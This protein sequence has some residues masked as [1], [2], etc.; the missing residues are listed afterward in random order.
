[1]QELQPN[2]TV[3]NRYKVLRKLGAG[4]MGSVYLCE[5][6]VENNIKVALKILISD[7][8][9]DQDIWAKGEYE[10]LTRLRHPNLARVY[11]FG[12]IGESK[13]YFIVSEFIK[14][15]DLFSATEYL[16]YDELVD[17]IV[18]ICR[19]LE[20]IHSQG[21]VHFDVKPD[22]IL[23]TRYKT[24]GIKEGSKVQYNEVD[25]ATSK[26]SMFAKPNV[27]L[28]DFGL[29]EKITG[30]FNFA[31]KGTL[32]Y[33]APEILN[34]QTP[35]KRADLYSL[36][37]TLYQVTNRDLPFYQEVTNFSGPPITKRSDL[38]GIHMKKHPEF[39]RTIILKLIEERPEDR[40]Q[41]AKEVTQFINKHS[42]YHF[43]IETAETRASYFYSPRLVGRRREMNLLKEYHERAF[44]PHRWKESIVA[45]GVKEKD[46]AP[47]AEDGAGED[48]LE[49]GD[50]IPAAPEGESEGSS[51]IEERAAVVECPALL[52]VSGEMGSGKSRLLE[53]FQHFLKLNDISLVVGS[54]YEGNSKAYQPFVEVLRQ[55]VYAFGLDSEFFKKYRQEFWK[56]LPE[57]KAQRVSDEDKDSSHRLDKEKLYFIE[58][59]S[60][61]LLEAAQLSPYVLVI[62]NLHWVDE[63]SVDFLET[64]LRRVGE[65]H[66]KGEQL[67][68]LVIASLRP[69]ELPL[70][71][72]R[73]LLEKLKRGG[74]C[75]DIPIRRLKHTQ[76]QEFLRAMLNFTDVPDAFVQKLEQKTGGNPLFIVETLKA[77]QDDGVIKNVGDGW[78]IKATNY[79][80]IE[81]PQRMEDLLEKRLGRLGAKKRE[82]V[83][84]LS[85]I[86]KPANPKFLQKMKRFEDMAILV[87]LRDLEQGGI[88]TKIF[89][90]GKLHFQITQPK[91]REILYS[92]IPEEN[93]RKYHGEVGAAFQELYSGREDEILEELAYHF[94]R[95]DQTLKALDLAIKAGDR[96]KGIYAND[97]A[98]EYYMYVL[99]KVEGDRE[100]LDLWVETH[101]KLG[102]LCTTMGRYDMADRSYHTLLEPDVLKALDALRVVKI[103]LARGRVFE[104]QGDYEHALKCFKDARNY[105]AGFKRGD[106]VVERIRVFNSIGWVY[107]CM[108]K[109]EKA[110]AISLE[111]LRVMEGGPERI[112]HAMVYN[113]I[114]SANSYKGNI[115][116]AIEYHRRSLHIKENLE[117]IPEI[118]ISL[119]NLGGAYMA[120]A[121]YGEAAEHF[122]RALKT[123]DET[124]DPYGKAVTLHNFARLYF[125]V[126]QP[127]K[128][129]EALDESLRL[130]KVY[131]MRYLNI[132]NYLVRGKA[133]R[134]EEEYTKAEGNYF[135]ALAAFT[136]QGNRWGL[137]TILINISELHR[138]RGHLEEARVM[139]DEAKRYAKDLDIHN[140]RAFCAIEEARLVRESGEEGLVQSVK[141]LEEAMVL[142]EKCDHAELW[143]EVNYEMGETLVRQRRL[144]E[145]TQCYKASE[146]RFGEVLENLPEEFRESYRTHLKKRYRDWKSGSKANKQASKA[147]APGTPQVPEA[148]SP[149]ANTAFTAENSLRRVNELMVLLCS[150]GPLKD[151]LGRI[152]EQ[153]LSV[154]KGSEA[155][156]LGINGQDLMVEV[157]RAAS[158][159]ALVEP[160]KVLCIPLIERV[161]ADQCSILLGDVAD[162]PEVA[163]LLDEEKI[164]ASSLAIIRFS[165]G[166]GRLGVLY[167]VNPQLQRGGGEGNLWVIQPFLNLVPLAYVQLSNERLAPAHA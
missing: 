101:E 59:I 32:N 120:G 97:R 7:N 155:Y 106:L 109:Y 134:D 147:D 151:F 17:I 41:S 24:V 71:S 164:T 166:P 163:K 136:K 23:V 86:D 87:E 80:R 95:S 44:F 138:L 146:E 37:V 159:E 114:G 88:I 56:L 90:G 25:L 103:F 117:N 62:N 149:D 83:E 110:M 150:G 70:E 144:R 61:L 115:R 127:E 9:D 148:A 156:L 84:V 45:A 91:V 129:W 67:G 13:D 118:T 18:Q 4:A 104:I 43:D 50:P 40:F 99:E 5:D 8:L 28:I 54:C 53:E 63:A 39:L 77:L 66:Q 19:A 152:L 76:I 157:A 145:A 94:Q 15:I 26:R 42:E 165:T 27:K 35:D 123:S 30:S 72:A 107:V 51:H 79:D 154:W 46:V 131:N 49:V 93:R 130:S 3:C 143:G 96:L 21:Y 29:A 89:E 48:T 128:G 161:L 74:Q 81:I 58:R 105:L 11:N 141:L 64:F 1:M 124:G 75:R 78:V 68:L 126:G 102:D 38:F 73:E 135:R 142:A 160:E 85:V 167:V 69:E 82:L 132:Q 47:A 112:E 133:L 111:A 2:E 16:H 108:G 139:L 92:R 153:I 55:L 6:S 140:L 158:G 12:R 33:L 100:H 34:G 20:Y 125:A 57:L 10:A 60:Q 31:I 119:N 113:T 52:L 122:Q 121:E 36:G 116:E 98:Y 14:G 162:D 65:V 22:N 137:C